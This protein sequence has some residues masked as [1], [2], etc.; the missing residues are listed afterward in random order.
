MKLRAKYILFIT[1]LHLVIAGLLFIVL[2]KNKI[3][4][5]LL[6]L[7]MLASV[8]FAIRL[9][10]DFIQP[11]NLLLTGAEAIRDQD[12]SVTL[13]HTGHSEM[14]Q[15]IDVYNLMIK[16]LRTERIQLAEQQFFLEKLLR[17]L[18]VGVLIL[19]FEN[20]LINC[21]PKAQ[22]L[23]GLK[24][25][26]WKNYPLF[27]LIHPLISYLAVLKDDVPQVVQLNG[28][29]KY[30]VQRS[31]FMD[32]GH[33][34]PFILI[35]ELSNDLLA[36]EKNA[37]GKVIRMMAHEVNNSIGPINSII[38]STQ[39]FLE[40]REA[41]NFVEALTIA[42]DRN[43]S[44]NVFMRRFAD[45]VRLPL[46]HKAIVDANVVVKSA[47]QIMQIPAQEAGVDLTGQYFS[48][49]LLIE[50][51]ADQIEQAL[52]NI[53]K[54]AIEACP[55]G[56]NIEVILTPNELAI[57]NNGNPISADI[58]NQLFSPFFST[59]PTGQGVGLMLTRDILLQHG[60]KFSLRTEPDGWT[61]FRIFWSK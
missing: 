54:N 53:L 15:L 11:I 17:A 23:L 51:D 43:K 24:Q 4:F 61:T 1:F 39:K 19:D 30:K 22:E 46:P 31:R 8:I 21:N 58:E 27:S 28:M 32:R 13:R 2:E 7:L 25:Q 35:E 10:R 38:E 14:D 52:I 60:W 40:K 57:R 41:G 26:S 45:V 9:Y 33:P 42:Y 6:E 59:K 20:R 48:S 29:E 16:N 44:L 3:A 5:I 36:N 50:L 55:Q 18:P 56:G 12:F 47:V 34:R 37:Y 49:A